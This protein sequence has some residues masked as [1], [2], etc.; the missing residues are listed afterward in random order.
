M[1]GDSNRVQVAFAKESSFGT[2]P[3]GE[4]DILR[5]T[6]EG[7]AQEQQTSR[8]SEIRSDR[9]VSDSKRTA[10]NSGGSINFEMSY[11]TFDKLLLG[12]LM[13]SA[14]STPA[15]VTDTDI[16]ISGPGSTFGSSGLGFGSFVAG[17]WVQVTGCTNAAN[18]GM[19]K[20]IAASSAEITVDGTLTTEASGATITITQ[21]AYATNG[22]EKNFYTF[23]RKYADLSNEIAIFAGCA[24]N[25]L[26]LSIASGQII[27]G[28]LT[29][30]GKDEVSATS[31]SGSGYAAVSTTEVMSAVDNVSSLLE[32]GSS[33]AISQLT[34]Q[35]SNSLRGKQKI[36][37]AGAFDIG[38]GTFD[39]T[40][41]FTAFYEDKT[42]VDKYLN[43]TSTSLV[44]IL[45]DIS[46]NYYLVEIPKIK[47][48]AGKRSG[49]SL[50]SDVMNEMS[51]QALVSSGDYTIKV[52]K[53]SA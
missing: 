53:F 29:I 7:L 47:L 20:I 40:G 23:E 50:D 43:Q 42:L 38:L 32:D 6:G 44:I 2:V 52:V 39:V 16:G 48:S 14:W 13:A 26:A 1:Y 49:G 35:L 37:S 45:K 19:F 33:L 51:F 8:S 31:S 41:T 15:T 36:G 18:N 9:Q 12:S 24:I 17:Q 5:H 25:Q 46:G 34:L 11:G 10:I 21:G 27:T 22:V 28:S 30:L 3:T 4:Y